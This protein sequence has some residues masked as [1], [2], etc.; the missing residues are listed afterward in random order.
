MSGPSELEIMLELEEVSHSYLA[1]K[2]N[3]ERGVH[4]VLSDVSL[5][6]FRG[7]SLGVV[8]RNGA[9]KTTLLR[10]M[11]GILE[12]SSGKIRRQHGA[13]FSL[14]SLGLGFQPQLTG[15]DNARPSAMLQG[16][17]AHIAEDYLESIK[18]FSELGDSFDE[19]VITYSAGMLARLGFSTALQTKVDVMLID[20]VLSVGDR[21]FRRKA[22]QAMKE[23]ITGEQTVVLVS[24]S[25]QHI[26]NMCDVA[27]WIQDGVL[28]AYGCVDE[29]LEQYV[30]A[31]PK[32]AIAN[33]SK[34]Q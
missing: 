15:R 9:G 16:A 6:L 23:R 22:T 31:D 29:V 14:L 26:K 19:P 7:E 1:R 11:A 17:T 4:Q 30:L 13:S 10:L 33:A 21:A 18:D 25:E 2:A 24:H 12:P 20:E 8:G 5:K 32:R 28:R 27:A 34:I 3:F